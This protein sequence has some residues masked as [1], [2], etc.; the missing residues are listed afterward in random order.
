MEK[1]QSFGVFS[2]ASTEDGVQIVA[3]VWCIFIIIIIILQIVGVCSDSVRTKFILDLAQSR[4]FF[5]PL[6]IIIIFG[7]LFD[8]I[9]IFHQK[10]HQ[11]TT[12]KNTRCFFY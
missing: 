7:L 6:I 5:L 1:K 3:V 8:G 9:S 11:E 10:H 2:G 4:R 12:N